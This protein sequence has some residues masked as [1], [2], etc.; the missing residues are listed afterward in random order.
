MDVRREVTAVNAIP[1]RVMLAGRYTARNGGPV[2]APVE[3]AVVVDAYLRQ[4]L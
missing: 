3:Y 4:L 1:R 2:T